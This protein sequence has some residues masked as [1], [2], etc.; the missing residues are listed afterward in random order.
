MFP[1]VRQ[2]RSDSLSWQR[3]L[4]W[5]GALGNHEG[6]TTH[7]TTLWVRVGEGSDRGQ[8]CCLAS[9][10]VP[11]RKLSPALALLPVTS[12]SPV[13]H[14]CPSSCCLVLKPRGWVC[15]SPETFVGPSGGVSRESCLFFCRPNP[16][17]FLQPEVM[18]TY[19]PGTGTVGWVV[20]CG[21]GIPCSPGIPPDFYPPHVNVGP[22]IPPPLHPLCPSC[23]SG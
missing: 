17:W 15:I 2:H 3:G 20:W 8:C 4:L 5:G 1:S 16:H 10:D 13:C 19:L 9:G 12:L 18:G 23:S 22:S 7:F 14:L 11:R 21:A 6:R